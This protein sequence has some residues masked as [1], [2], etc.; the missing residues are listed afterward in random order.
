MFFFVCNFLWLLDGFLAAHKEDNDAAFHSFKKKLYHASISAILQPVKP[1]I[2]IPVVHC[3]LDGHW[4]HVIFNLAVFIADYPKQ[5]MLSGIIQGWC[6]KC[7][8]GSIL[9]ATSLTFRFQ[10]YSTCKWSW[11][12]RRAT[13]TCS[14]LPTVWDTC[15]RWALA[16]IWNRHHYSGW[17]FF[18]VQVWFIDKAVVSH[19]PIISL[20]WI[21]MYAM[22]SPDLLHQLIKGTFKDH[23][24]TWTC[25]WIEA[26]CEPT[27]CL[28][29][30]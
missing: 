21:Y 8:Q 20:V 17:F 13:H 4:C 14:A 11:W 10:M 23:L 24:V 3:C 7:V 9:L 29:F 27:C 12:S 30:R 22:I 6:S 2:I 28:P 19:S 5:V 16:W 18:L 15:H 26:K 1:A 25:E